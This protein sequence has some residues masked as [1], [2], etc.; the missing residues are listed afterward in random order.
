MKFM[1]ETSKLLDSWSVSGNDFQTLYK[2]LEELSARTKVLPI[3]SRDIRIFTFQKMKE[4]EIFGFLHSGQKSIAY[5]LPKTEE[6][7]ESGL[8][9]ELESNRLMFL[10]RQDK[11]WSTKKVLRT[12]SQRAGSKMGD[13]AMCDD[14]VVSFHR[15]A[16]YA[17]YMTVNPS[18]CM[19]LYR[20]IG[21]IKKAYAVFTDVYKMIPQ[22]PIVK[23]LIE[24][25]EK[26]MGQA[27]LK[28]YSIDNYQTDILVTFPKVRDDFARTYNLP[29]K[30]SPG[31]HIHMSDVGDSS[32]IIHGMIGVRNA[33]VYIPGAEY[34]RP[35]TKKASLDQIKKNVEMKVFSE[36]TKVPKRMLEL[37]TIDVDDTE[38][39]IP[40]L[41]KSCGF[42]R[43]IGR[44][45]T[46]KLIAEVLQSLGSKATAYEV[47]TLLLE[48]EEEYERKQHFYNGTGIDAVRSAFMNA[49]F[50]NYD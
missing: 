13:F 8:V 43:A 15:N 46:K 25:F 45:A 37:L 10:M 23:D 1:K 12:L 36:Y 38:S 47:A 4:K 31:L 28:C 19:V 30:L 21:G 2:E 5:T 6:E 18:D 44:I 20:E 50:F 39:L 35:H 24:A 42:E 49:L 16:G 7:A 22:F 17:A 26:E 3:N 29:V 41:F 34:T 11:M 14:P 32:F 40:K 33:V 27:V 48:Y 9:Q